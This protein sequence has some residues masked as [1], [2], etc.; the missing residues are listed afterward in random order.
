MATE[1]QIAKLQEN[2]RKRNRN[3]EIRNV[4]QI[5]NGHGAKDRKQQ[6]EARE[7]LVESLGEAEADSE[8]EKAIKAVAP[9][10]GLIRK[11]LGR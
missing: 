8:Q 5:A 9:S 11:M 3:N 6:R 2:Q 7:V 10:K 1:K 4:A